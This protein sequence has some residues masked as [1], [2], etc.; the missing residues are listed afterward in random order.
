MTADR[1]VVDVVA[2]GVGPA[3]LSLAAL[4]EPITGLRVLALERQPHFAWHSGMMVPGA[5]LQVIPL[6]DLVS[7]VDPTN[8][9][10]FLN[11]LAETGR[12]YRFLVANRNSVARREFEQYY[13]WAASRL[14]SVRFGTEVRTVDHDG[15]SFVVGTDRETIRGRNVVLGVGQVP[16]LPSFAR[17]WL[18][19]DVFHSD[20]YLRCER[21]TAGRDIV[22]TGGGQSAAELALH[23]LAQPDAL[24]RSLTW[25]TG[26][27][28]LHPLDDSPFSNDWFTPGYA[29][30][31]HALSGSRRAELLARQELASDGVSESLL[32]DIYR[33]LYELDY[34]GGGP[35]RH[36]LL[37]GH[38]LT[39]LAPRGDRYVATISSPDVPVAAAVEADVVI[40]A[41]GYRPHVP[42]FLAPLADRLL[43]HE[44]RYEVDTQYRVAWDGPAG[45]RIYVQN[46][47]RH[48]HGIAD[49][50][51]SLNAWRSAVIL[52]DVAGRPVYRTDR[53]DTTID[54]LP[55]GAPAPG[56]D[57]DRLPAMEGSNH[58]S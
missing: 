13:A 42:E 10:S 2:V 29:R 15:E 55:A 56:Q 26:R 3:N 49:P 35:L 34:L 18:G 54:H 28:G 12:L 5:A 11:F 41:T 38:R 23:L 16:H 50:N 48:T 4:A 43:L 52:N 32:L 6:K 51:L 58:G 40:L 47:A 30:Y 37:S 7:L 19:R 57:D 36:R 39:D 45:H 24:P 44:G 21:V 8:R 14:P 31:F 46:A 27:S 9:H 25:L 17:P 20:D 33:R 1:H 53:Y 22:L